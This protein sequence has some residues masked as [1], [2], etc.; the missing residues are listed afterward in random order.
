MNRNPGAIHL[1]GRAVCMHVS[2]QIFGSS[3]E[4]LP[5]TAPPCASTLPPRLMVHFRKMLLELSN[6]F[7]DLGVPLPQNF[8]RLEGRGDDAAHMAQGLHSV[9]E[10]DL[11]ALV[12]TF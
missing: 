2:W 3:V 1:L 10:L 12:D 5:K 9:S 7:V 4:S 6:G 11:D 8:Q